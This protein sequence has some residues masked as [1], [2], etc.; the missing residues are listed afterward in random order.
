MNQLLSD[1]VISQV[2]GDC[3]LDSKTDYYTEEEYYEEEIID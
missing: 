1:I 3:I 2:S